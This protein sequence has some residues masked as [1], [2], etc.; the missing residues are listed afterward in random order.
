MKPSLESKIIGQQEAVEKVVKAIR[1]N[2][3]GL[4]DPKKPIG[5]FMLL[6]PT[7][8]GKSLLAKLLAKEL[9]GSEML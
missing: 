2:R 9:F 1:R 7:G 3:I 8:V 6:G 5:V 4:K